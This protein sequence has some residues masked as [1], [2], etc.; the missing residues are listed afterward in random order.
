LL[1]RAVR[2]LLPLI[3]TACS[4]QSPPIN[5]T[6][7]PTVA[8]AP[9]SVPPPARIAITGFGATDA[10]WKLTHVAD[11]RFP[12]GHLYNLSAVTPG[13]DEYFAVTHERG[14]V[15]GYNLELPEHTS[16]A[17]A[18]RRT[19]A[20]LPSDAIILWTAKRDACQQEEFESATLLPI[21]RSL[22]Y[23]TGQVYVELYTVDL[24]TGDTSLNARDINEALIGVGVFPKASDA[25]PC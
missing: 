6:S 10:D 21:M 15:T 11:P 23:H 8:P 17:S 5:V 25:P 12:V 7:P 18:E 2:A 22:G 24:T 13:D 16:L 3:L 14:R 9:T 20:E 19:K 1:K 4:S